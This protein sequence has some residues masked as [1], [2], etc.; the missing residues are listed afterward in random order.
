MDTPADDARFMR[1]AL[2]QAQ[3]GAG[4]GEV[5][6][7]AVVVR[8]GRIVARAHNAPIA[9]HDPTAHA[10]IAALR[11]AAAALGNYRLEDCTL[12]VTLEPC[13]MCSGA[14]LQARLP[15]VVFGASEPRTGAAGSVFNLFDSAL[16][17]QTQVSSGVLADEASRLLQDFFAQRR[18]QQ[19]NSHSPLS[20]DA[21][22]HDDPVWRE[23]LSR[24]GSVQACF[25]Q[26]WPV[27]L[28]DDPGLS[29][30]KTHATEPA[31]VG[32]RLHWLD[33]R[34]GLR[35]QADEPA[36][37]LYLHGPDQWSGAYLDAL[38]QASQQGEA[39]LALDWLGFGG[40][41]KPKKE[42]VYSTALHAA[43][44]RAFLQRHAV[45]EIRCPQSVAP[46]LN[47]LAAENHSLPPVVWIEPPPMDDVWARLPY[48]DRGHE[49][50]RR[51]WRT[52]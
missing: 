12:Y 1:E 38:T 3:Q 45:R 22:R 20:D 50:A 18:A 4:Q 41:D 6:V 48:P 39:A 8:N 25:A 47:V 49:V 46:V 32:W 24:N 26:D 31:R 5:P 23:V 9:T 17:H 2:L 37:V 11:Q 10:E 16:N 30:N 33:N 14:I 27:L 13:A 29:S 36:A 35:S 43:V 19:A 40:S 44:L 51:A 21:L 15:R 52:I 42:A 28:G 34:A 7:G